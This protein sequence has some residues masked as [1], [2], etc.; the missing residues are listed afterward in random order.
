MLYF[1]AVVN[2]FKSDKTWDMSISMLSVSFVSSKNINRTSTFQ[3][4]PANSSTLMHPRLT[5]ALMHEN[6]SCT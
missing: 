4:K 5:G 2:W 3:M 1:I 6:L